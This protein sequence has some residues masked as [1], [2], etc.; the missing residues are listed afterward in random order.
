MIRRG[1]IGALVGAGAAITRKKQA[2]AA[3]SSVVPEDEGIA[4]TGMPNSGSK[5]N[6]ENWD[7]LNTLTETNRRADRRKRIARNLLGGYP[8]CIASHHSCAPW[9]K[10]M[11]AARKIE[12]EEHEYSSWYNKIQNKIFGDD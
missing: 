1:F 4:L 11:V 2:N 8:P 9:F 3:L 6:A 5:Y 10:A 7:L 12:A